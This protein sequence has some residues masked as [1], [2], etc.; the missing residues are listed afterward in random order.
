MNIGNYEVK[1][2]ISEGGFAR[3]YQAKHTLLD[4]LACIKQP[5]QNSKDYQDLLRG[6]AQILWDLDDHHS[7]PHVKDLIHLGRGLNVMVMSYIDGKNLEDIIPKGS[8]IHQED[9]AWIGER[10]LGALYYCHYNGVVHGDIKPGNI[11]VEDQKHDIKLID[12]GLSTFK[13]ESGTKPVGYT[14]SFAA[15]EVLEGKPPIPESDIYGAG[16]VMLYALGGNPHTL[17][18]PDDIHPKLREFTMS[19]VRNDPMSRPNWDKTNL[20]RKLSDVR[21]EAFGRRRSEVYKHTRR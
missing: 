7:I 10:L 9:A 2:M 11:I 12:F 8:R 17:S 6:E 15:P 4:R 14:E 21:K 1:N 5:K 20:I 13:P 16:V 19:L 18:I 3:I